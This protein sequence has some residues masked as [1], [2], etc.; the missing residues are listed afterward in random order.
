[1]R[2]PAGSGLSAKCIKLAQLGFTKTPPAFWLRAWSIEATYVAGSDHRFLISTIALIMALLVA[3]T[4][5]ESGV[6]SVVEVTYGALFG[7]FCTL[8]VFQV[9]S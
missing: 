6:H 9:F 7:A 5:V 3:Q 8:I 4:R 2:N 1:M